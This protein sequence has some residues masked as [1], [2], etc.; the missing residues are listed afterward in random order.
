MAQQ[1]MTPDSPH[2]EEFISRLE[3]PEGCNFQADYD[4]EGEIIADT[5][6]WECEGG[7]DKSKAAAILR[8][9]PKIDVAASLAFFEEQGGYCDCEIVFNVEEGYRGRQID[10]NG[11]LK[12]S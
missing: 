3:G 10:S 12:G 7:E 2:W 5:V 6:T 4:D 1:I 8:T 9:I 11:F